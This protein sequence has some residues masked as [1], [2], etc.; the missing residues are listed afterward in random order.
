MQRPHRA[1]SFLRDLWGHP[2]GPVGRGAPGSVGVSDTRT[3]SHWEGGQFSSLDL[4]W[5]WL[6]KGDMSELGKW[7]PLNT[8]A[9]PT[10]P[11]LSHNHRPCIPGSCT[12]SSWCGEG[13]G[14]KK[15]APSPTTRADPWPQP[16]PLPP[17]PP[18]TL[19][20]QPLWTSWILDPRSLSQLQPPRH[21]EPYP[22]P[23]P[24]S[25]SPGSLDPRPQLPP[26]APT[27]SPPGSHHT[28]PLLP[29]HQNLSLDF[30]DLH[31]SPTPVLA[32]W[33]LDPW[34]P[35]NTHPSI[36]PAPLVLD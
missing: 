6:A 5:V 33:T 26:P 8:V 7:K 15:A 35:N 22:P 12:T 10:H 27:P 16:Q 2:L 28:H 29:R 18:P 30:L 1:P 14:R 19:C 17:A 9:L 20:P 13:K 24:P 32:A 36:P 25:P 31:P 4:R 23:A 34:A 11:G 21:H 3:L